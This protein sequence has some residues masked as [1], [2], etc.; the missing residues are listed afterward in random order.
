LKRIDD[1]EKRKPI[2]ISVPGAYAPDSMLAH[3]DRCVRIVE[4]IACQVRKLRDNLLADL[5]VPLRGDKDVEARGGEERHDE[6]PR[7]RRLHGT[8]ITRG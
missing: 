1:F 4:Q 8:R 2:E 3:A 5:G 7:C 6:V